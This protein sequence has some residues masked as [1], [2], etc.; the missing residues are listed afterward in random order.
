VGTRTNLEVFL[1]YSTN[2]GSLATPWYLLELAV[3]RLMRHPKVSQAIAAARSRAGA[4]AA[5]L[6]RE[7]EARIKGNGYAVLKAEL[8]KLSR[9]NQ[10]KLRAQGRRIYAYIQA[11]SPEFPIA[12]VKRSTEINSDRVLRMQSNS[13]NLLEVGQSGSNQFFLMGKTDSK[14]QE[15]GYHVA[16]KAPLLQR[17]VMLDDR[18]RASPNLLGTVIVKGQGKPPVQQR[19]CNIGSFEGVLDAQGRCVPFS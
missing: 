18:T 6:E 16:L 17:M 8:E 19:P 4:A 5:N 1:T 13:P 12:S 15:A 9:K 14:G 10:S 2:G 11:A 3:P 7:I